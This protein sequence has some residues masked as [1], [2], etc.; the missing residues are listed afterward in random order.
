MP[1]GRRA[2][3]HRLASHLSLVEPHGCRLILR[4]SLSN[5]ALAHDIPSFLFLLL[6]PGS[7]QEPANPHRL[8]CPPP[9]PLFPQPLLATTLLSPS[10]KGN[11][12]S[13]PESWEHPLSLQ[14]FP[15]PMQFAELT[16]LKA[17]RGGPAWTAALGLPRLLLPREPPLPDGHA[18]PSRS[19]DS[20]LSHIS[21][22]LL[23]AHFL[24]GVTS[25]FLPWARLWPPPLPRAPGS[26]G[27]LLPPHHEP[28]FEPQDVRLS[29]PRG[30]VQA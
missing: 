2:Q 25:W 16:L 26:P 5:Q 20:A 19:H 7:S 24:A 28:C 27:E 15:S 14:S 22:G 3:S 13:P 17:N 29:G 18:G 30:G 11:A 9:T 1:S 12:W 8:S 21:P 23:P 4:L 10:Q 6:P